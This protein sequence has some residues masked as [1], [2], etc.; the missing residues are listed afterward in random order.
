MN[1][2]NNDKRFEIDNVELKFFMNILSNS[3]MFKSCCSNLVKQYMCYERK[4]LIVSIGN[5]IPYATT[6]CL[7]LITNF[8][9]QNYHQKYSLAKCGAFYKL[10]Q[11]YPGLNL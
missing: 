11:F 5:V 4:D 8:Q 6:K 10:N 3:L 1:N 2:N 9:M 7:N